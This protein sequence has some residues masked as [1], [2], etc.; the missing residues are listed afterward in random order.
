MRAPTDIVLEH[1]Q[2]PFSLEW[3][4]QLKSAYEQR[5]W[6]GLSHVI[7]QLLRFLAAARLTGFLPEEQPVLQ[8]ALKLLL[9][10]L[11][12]PDFVFT[13]AHRFELVTHAVTL[14][15]A[16]NEVGLESTDA[17]L[18]TLSALPHKR[19]ELLLCSSLYNYCCAVHCIMRRCLS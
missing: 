7:L 17:L 5:D 9:L 15:R 10:T 11:R 12:D 13:P 1:H 2:P 6:D 3:T 8:L 19:A 16:L 14:A 18:E 4:Q